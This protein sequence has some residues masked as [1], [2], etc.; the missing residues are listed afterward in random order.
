MFKVISNF[1][2]PE[3]DP[4]LIFLQEK[5]KEYPFTFWYDKFPDSAEQLRINPYNFLFLHEPNEFFGY[6]NIAISTYDWFS[7]IF[8]W[9]N[10]VLSNV[11]NGILFTYNGATLDLDF[12][13]Q[14]ENK[15]KEFEVS[16]LCGTKKLVEGH[17]LRHK[18]YDLKNNI[19]IPN[20]WY[21]VLEDYDVD[22]NVRPGYQNYSKDISHIPLGV[23]IIGYGRRVLFE[24]SMFNVVIENVNSLNWYNKIGDNFLSKTIP[25]YW[26][27]IILVILD[28]MKEV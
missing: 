23:D 24:N 2:N 25:I 17:T 7:G 14:M 15:E 26:D 20:K 6:H 3:T 5:Y 13:K 11:N 16:F 10:D 8:T 28:M 19:N 22:N 21:Y 18:V 27:V 9:N 4:Y 12:I 1:R